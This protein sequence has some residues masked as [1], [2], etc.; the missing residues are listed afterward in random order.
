M[1]D[2][3]EPDA[4][5]AAGAGDGSGGKGYWC[6]DSCVLMKNGYGVCT[7]ENFHSWRPWGLTREDAK[8][9]FEDHCKRSGNH[10]DFWTEWDSSLLQS[11]VDFAEPVFIP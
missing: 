2:D 3:A 11:L 6:Y 7:T 5:D 4:T 9:G 10:R 8:I 1:G